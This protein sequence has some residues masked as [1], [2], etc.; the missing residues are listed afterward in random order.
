MSR[1]SYYPE[2]YPTDIEEQ[3][4]NLFNE[5]T[6]GETE[7]VVSETEPAYNDYDVK[8]KLVNYPWYQFFG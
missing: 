4:E 3:F 2:S 6:E 5:D 8:S 7:E 1:T